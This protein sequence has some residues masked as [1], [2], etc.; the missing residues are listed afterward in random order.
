MK[1][2]L[3]LLFLLLTVPLSLKALQHDTNSLSDKLKNHVA[4]L[5]ADS[6]EGRGLGTEGKI[7]AKHYIAGEFQSA[8]VQPVGNTYFQHLDLR[9]GLAR[10]PGANVV[11]YLEGSNP[12][13]RDEFIILGA[14]Y[15]H[16]GY[17]REN[18]GKVIF[19]F[20]KGNNFYHRG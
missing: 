19:T 3:P 17:V 7:L 12:K 1:N 20:S 10:V 2:L 14:H 8:G 15:D 5:A 11:G 18:G 9:I 16:L 6:M 13:L 4:V